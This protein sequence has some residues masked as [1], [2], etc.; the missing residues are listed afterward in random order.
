MMIDQFL[1]AIF[2]LMVFIFVVHF[3]LTRFDRRRTDRPIEHK[4][5]HE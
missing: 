3:M 4:I 2:D 5:P 1:H